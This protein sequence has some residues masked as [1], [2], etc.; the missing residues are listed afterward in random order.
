MN[1]YFRVDASLNIGSGHV[2]RCLALAKALKKDG[3]SVVF[4]VREHKGHMIPTIEMAG[5]QVKRLPIYS[6]ENDGNTLGVSWEKDAFETANVFEEE[7]PPDWLIV[8]H[9]A[10]D[11]CWHKT[12]RPYVKNIFVIDDV[13][14]K[15]IDCDL[16]LNQNLGYSDAD[17]KKF[18]SESTQ[19]LL[20][21]KY[22]LLRTEFAELRSK[23][24]EKRQKYSEVNSIFIS[25]GALDVDNLTESV[26]DALSKLTWS[27]SVE[28]HVILGEHAPHFKTIL[29]KV[30][31][32]SF[33]VRLHKNVSNMSEFI[34]QAD[35]AIG[36]A[37]STAWERCCLGLPSLCFVLADNQQAIA[38][39]L[40][41]KKA[42]VNLGKH[43]PQSMKSFVSSLEDL[44]KNKKTWRDMSAQAFTISD[45]QGVTLVKNR[46]VSDAIVS[47]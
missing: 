23:A 29:K 33:C 35:I 9:Y 42:A 14:E 15:S 44:L 43:G 5:F 31:S 24:L 4:I 3:S 18:V 39:E 10:I 46:L 6:D 40:G 1:I 20:G 11:Q 16:L 17:Y 25:F 7:T 30:K 27:N 26:L 2:M 38:L 36:A 28:V 21:P 41:S 37:G 19:F 12:L 13:P 22:A 34:L 47:S 45:G 32:Y 8:D